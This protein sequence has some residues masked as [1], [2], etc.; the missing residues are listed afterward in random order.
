MASNQ[1]VAYD[2]RQHVQ[3]DKYVDAKDKAGR[4][5][6]ATVKSF[7]D[8]GKVQ[9]VFDGQSANKYRMVLAVHCRLAQL[10]KTPWRRRELTPEATRA[11]KP[12]SGRWVTILRMR[13][14]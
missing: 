14:K 4:W 3:H 10:P 2:W 7:T 13:E 9:V 6:L 8:D 11:A 12:A 5:M 1:T